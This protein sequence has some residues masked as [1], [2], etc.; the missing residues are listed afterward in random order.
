MSSIVHTI[1]CTLD[2]ININVKFISIIVCNIFICNSKRYKKLTNYDNVIC[3]I[4]GSMFFIIFYYVW[5]NISQIPYF[6]STSLKINVYHLLLIHIF[7][8]IV[9]EV[10]LYKLSQSGNEKYQCITSH[11]RENIY[12]CS[13]KVT[14]ILD[15]TYKCIFLQ[16][17]PNQYN[18]PP[19]LENPFQCRNY[20]GQSIRNEIVSQY[21]YIYT[22]EIVI[23]IVYLLILPQNGYTFEKIHHCSSFISDILFIFNRIRKYTS[24]H[25]VNCLNNVYSLYRIGRSIFITYHHEYV[26]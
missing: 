5:S 12:Q 1:C 14:H 2:A 11:T 8:V 18:S 24:R 7:I 16:D 19:S 25:T 26:R 10:V 17:I 22:G 23:G 13:D 4:I 21:I 3:S 20:K 9:S 15:K 6:K